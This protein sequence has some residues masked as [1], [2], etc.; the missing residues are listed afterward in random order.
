MAGEVIFTVSI[1]QAKFK[2]EP[3]LFVDLYTL[4]MLRQKNLE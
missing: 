2:H 1:P 3:R 4:I